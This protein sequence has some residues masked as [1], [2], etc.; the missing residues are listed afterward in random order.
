MALCV[1][2]KKETSKFTLIEGIG[3]IAVCEECMKA[4]DADINAPRLRDLAQ[5]KPEDQ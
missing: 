5:R 4:N 2:C 1:H 3:S